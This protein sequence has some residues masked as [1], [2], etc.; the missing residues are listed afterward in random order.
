M[1]EAMTEGG[2]KPRGVVYAPEDAFNNGAVILPYLQNYPE[3][4]ERLQEG[5]HYS[6]EDI[7]FITPVKHIHQVE[8]YGFVFQTPRH[9]FSWITDTKIFK[10]LSAYYKADL[11]IINV[12]SLERGIPVD[13]LSLP[14]AEEIINEIK[15]KMAIL[16]HF[17]IT[18]WRSQ[19]PWE[20]DKKL[21]DDTGVKVIAARDGMVFDFAELDRI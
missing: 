20:A 16:T 9:K 2:W 10:S 3:R 18:M 7:T 12:L 21:S 17:G 11:I 8:T 15:P 1:I 5:H 14:D 6:L 13:H 4:I 19:K